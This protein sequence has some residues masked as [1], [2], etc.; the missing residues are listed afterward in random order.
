MS[1]DPQPE[2][3]PAAL[4]DE[5]AKAYTA[6]I[7]LYQSDQDEG[8]VATPALV[9]LC[10]T[11]P[12]GWHPEVL[13]QIVADGYLVEDGPCTV[14]SSSGWR[15]VVEIREEISNA[16]LARKD[17]ELK[18]HKDYHAQEQAVL[19]EIK[20]AEATVESKKG[21][22]QAAK[23]DLEAA[24][25]SLAALVAGGVQTSFLDQRGSSPVKPKE[26]PLVA[27]WSKV[28]PPVPPDQV[29]CYPSPGVP[30]QQV[31]RLALTAGEAMTQEKRKVDAVVEAFGTPWIVSAIWTEAATGATRANLLRLYSK[32]EWAQLKEA[33]FGRA[34]DG[35]DQS[36]D[37]K[38][39]RQ[40]GGA[41]CGLVVRH[42]RKVFVV[43]PQSDAL[44]LV[45]ADEVKQ[46][47]AEIPHDGK[48]AAANDEGD[49]QEPEVI[50]D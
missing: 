28:L 34:V 23:A 22:L 25:E 35:F 15:R 8:D 27:E 11:M 43:G 14:L 1:S 20:A 12:E 41:W 38:A 29:R 26:E 33:D 19:N 32:D 6:T 49:D 17:D 47:A 5:H 36:D 3:V 37:A 4:T 30:V 16:A 9:K 24:H 48:M 40:K 21:A 39:A 13:T 18:A 46:D 7:L 2:T 10:R 45:H 42:G 44:H 50:D 31:V